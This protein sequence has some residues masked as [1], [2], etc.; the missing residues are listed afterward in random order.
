MFGVSTAYV[1]GI[2]GIPQAQVGVDY[3]CLGVTSGC[4]PVPGQGSTISGTA[5]GTGTPFTVRVYSLSPSSINGGNAVPGISVRLVNDDGTSGPS[6][7]IPSA[8]CQTGAPVDGITPDPYSVLTDD[9]GLATCTPVFG[10][11]GGNIHQVAVLVGGVPAG[12]WSIPG[13]AAGT[14]YNPSAIQYNPV[15][16]VIQPLPGYAM[17][18]FINLNVKAATIGSVIA[19]G[20]NNQ[21]AN[22][23]QALASPLV[24]TVTDTS[25]KPLAGQGVTWT[26]SP[27]AAATLSNATSVTNSNGQA[28][29]NVTFTSSA[30]G[31]V[32]IKATVGGTTSSTTFTATAVPPVVITGL[33]K[34][35]GDNQSALVS[36]PFATPLQVQVAV[37]TGSV[38]NIPVSWSV[39]G[40]A[41][42]SATSTPTNASGVAQV[43]VTA[44]SSAGSV[45]V[46][47]SAGSASQTF[48]L[49]VAPP[50]TFTA[51]NFVNGADQQRGSISACGLATLAA[52]VAPAVSGTVN[53]PLVGAL[54]LALAGVSIAFNSSDY[55]PILSVSSSAVNF[56]VPCDLTAGSVSVTVA[57]GGSSGTVTL[58]LLGAGPGIF[59]T[60]QSDG[61]SRAV[62]ERPDGTF[63]S[64]SNPARRGEFVTAFVTGLGPVS[65]S[66]A[67]N[68]LP[69]P[70]T[71]STVNGQVIVGV[72]NAGTQVQSAVLSPDRQ[73]V[74]LITF[75]IPQSTPQGNNVVF[76]V[77]VVPV[78][79]S[80]PNYSAGSKIPVQ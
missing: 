25:G 59:S 55:A 61:V 30:L 76:S 17:T 67:T 9:N 7:T 65:P 72:N 13:T 71:P 31:P 36:T 29:T 44:G 38:A 80:A 6:P 57:A 39:N 58:T 21:S 16:G 78:G 32:S 50:V 20:G 52:P 47:A 63:V 18:G 74:Y 35:A 73:G 4:T 23:G 77:G 64:L 15:P 12:E 43:T 51:S 5:G 79:S 26:A 70:G 56:L 3:Q 33:T 62:I 24:V 41:T 37:S 34:V 49:V 19:T 68:A 46:T 60:V 28:S 53:A 27:A 54:P 48:N 11:V 14:L 8:Y 40:P 42:L 66:V 22:P 1:S 2:T 10:P 45:A 69:I 75:Q